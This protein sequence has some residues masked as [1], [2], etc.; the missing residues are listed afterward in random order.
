[1]I[2][3]SNKSRHTF[4]DSRGFFVWLFVASEFNLDRNFRFDWLFACFIKWRYFGGVRYLVFSRV[5]A[6]HLLAGPD[7]MCL[8]LS[9][10]FAELRFIFFFDH[11]PYV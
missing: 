2:V 7:C 8:L 6:G 3:G 11:D 4:G 10:V 5:E 1:M 9:T